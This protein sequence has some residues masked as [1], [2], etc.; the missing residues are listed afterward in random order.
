MTRKLIKNRTTAE[1]KMGKGKYPHYVR[2]GSN[3]LASSGN[4]LL[5]NENDNKLKEIET[6]FHYEFMTRRRKGKENSLS[7]NEL[8]HEIALVKLFCAIIFFLNNQ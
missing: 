5:S 8:S 7:V 6:D 3:E 1:I 2:Q 4:G